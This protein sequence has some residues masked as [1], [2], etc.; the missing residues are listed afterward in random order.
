MTVIVALTIS[1][2]MKRDD[3]EK[4]GASGPLDWIRIVLIS[5][6]GFLCHGILHGISFVDRI[7]ADENKD[8]GKLV[9]LVCNRVGMTRAQP[10]ASR[11]QRFHVDL[12]T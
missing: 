10:F 5:T 11:G 2:R 8:L 12:E 3:P 7:L 6:Q 9:C 1:H 4:P